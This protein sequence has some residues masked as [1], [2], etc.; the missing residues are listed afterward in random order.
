M[1]TEVHIVRGIPREAVQKDLPIAGSSF[2]AAAAADQSDVCYW[3]SE[4]PEGHPGQ[5]VYWNS[6]NYGVA[7]NA[8]GQA[9]YDS[10]AKL[11]ASWGIDLI[12]VDCIANPYRAEEIRML[13]LAVKKTGRP[14]ILSLSPGPTPI[15][16]A[17]EARKYAQMW[18]ISNDVLDFWSPQGFNPGIKGQFALAAKWARYSGSGGWPD[19]DMLP[20]GYLGPRVTPPRPTRLLEVNNKLCLRYGPCC[21]C[22]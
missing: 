17:E 7:A 1:I 9:Y 14:M 13:S 20:I 12:K 16:A 3:Q 22:R 8:A 18:R 2:H 21:V 10:L 5:R 6:D 11:Y 15:G 4:T 19:A